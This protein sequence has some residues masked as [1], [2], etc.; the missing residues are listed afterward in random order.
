MS[1]KEVN[2]VTDESKEVVGKNDEIKVYWVLA[3]STALVGQ[4]NSLRSGL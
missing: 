2:G 3:I 4:N 1:A